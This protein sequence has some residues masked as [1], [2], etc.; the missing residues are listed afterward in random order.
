[1]TTNAFGVYLESS[2]RRTFAGALDWPG[3]IRSGRNEASALQALLDSAPRYAR[4]LQSAGIEFAPPPDAAA[5]TI[6]E[7]LPGNATTEFGAP[8]IAPSADAQ[9]IDDAELARLQALLAAYW[10]AFD[11]AVAE[12]MGKQL[13]KGP[14]G[15]GRELHA[16]IEHV[17][18]GEQAYLGMLAWKWTKPRSEDLAVVQ[19]ATRQAVSDALTAAA[20]G[21]TPTQRPRGGPAWPPRYFVRRHGWHVLDHAWE[22][23]DRIT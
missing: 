5:F 11:T 22:I 9:P 17:T 1:M 6:A 19:H 4:V 18:G 12:A 23:E 20:H 21:R 15:G 8:S 16:I 2:A 7:R 13:R 3:W 10:T 14:R